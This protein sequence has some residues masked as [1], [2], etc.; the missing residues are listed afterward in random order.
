MAGCAGVRGYAGQQG[1][2][3]NLDDEV[4]CF[5]FQRPEEKVVLQRPGKAGN[6]LRACSY[7]SKLRRGHCSEESGGWRA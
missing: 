7:A 1:Q 4:L 5:L 6:R 3:S 2:G